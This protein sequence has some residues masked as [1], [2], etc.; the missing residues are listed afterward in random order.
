MGLPFPGF[1]AGSHGAGGSTSDA[2]C[3]AWRKIST[4]KNT[5]AIGQRAQTIAGL[6]YFSLLIFHSRI[7]QMAGS[8]KKS[9]GFESE[10]LT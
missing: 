1:T 7:S 6:S 5:S 8:E 4:R 9:P 2:K 10:W 3:T